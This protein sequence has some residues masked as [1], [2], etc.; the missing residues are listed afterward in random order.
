MG[1]FMPAGKVVRR[2]NRYDSNNNVTGAA[3]ARSERIG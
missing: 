3:Y 1:E 2:V